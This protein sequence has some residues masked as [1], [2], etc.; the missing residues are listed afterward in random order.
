MALEELGKA[1]SC[2]IRIVDEKES[3]ELNQ[4]YRHKPGPTNVLSFPFE[5][6]EGLDRLEHEDTTLLGDLIIC[7]PVVERE[8]IAQNKPLLHHWAHMTVHGLLHLRG[9][10]HIEEHEA[11]EMEIKEIAIL[12]KLHIENPYLEVIHE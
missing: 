8:A 6:P 12:K 5:W 11:E 10:D 3:A 9:Y 7:A 1:Y 4:H 2:V